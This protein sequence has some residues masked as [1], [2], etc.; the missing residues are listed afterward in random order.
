[1][2]K[3]CI[4]INQHNANDKIGMTVPEIVIWNRIIKIILEL[5]NV[6]FLRFPYFK[7]EIFIVNLHCS[8][9]LKIAQLNALSIAFFNGKF[10]AEI[11]SKVKKSRE[12]N[13]C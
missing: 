13:I 8:W 4:G 9:K 3:T 12:P 7:V 2:H 11:Y 10:T 5:A 6:W 1:M